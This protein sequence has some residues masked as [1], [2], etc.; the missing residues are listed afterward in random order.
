MQ[1][2][3]GCIK[4]NTFSTYKATINKSIEKYAIQMAMHSKS[5]RSINTKGWVSLYMGIHLVT[6]KHVTTGLA[7]PNTVNWLEQGVR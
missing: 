2:G 4:N 3:I 6:E 7:K 5:E 1:G